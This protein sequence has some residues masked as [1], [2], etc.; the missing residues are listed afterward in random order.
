MRGSICVSAQRLRAVSTGSSVLP[1]GVI[2][3]STFGGT[4]A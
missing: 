4:S 3:Y 2:E 1:N